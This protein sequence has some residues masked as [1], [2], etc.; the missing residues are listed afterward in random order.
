M[1]RDEAQ[2]ID[3]YVGARL[4]LRRS[5][6]GLSQSALAQRLGVSFQQVQKYE[7]GQNR[8]SA[9][10]LHR[11]A[12]VLGAPIDSFFPPAEADV[13]DAAHEAAALGLLGATAEGRALAADFPR[14][15]SVDERRAVARI[16]RGLARA[17]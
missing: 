7:T 9:S 13:D 4:S 14:I 5:A 2:A 17:A 1:T 6:L 8:M 10:R 3:I 11:A 12:V 16:V 15:V